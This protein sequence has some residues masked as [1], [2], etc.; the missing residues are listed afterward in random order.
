[1]RTIHGIDVHGIDVDAETRCAHYDT[2]CDVIAIRF[3]C[4]NE[5]Y[6]CF[7]C[8]DAVADHPRET[9]AKDER[10]TEAVLCGVCGS[11][12]T[13]SEYLGCESQCPE[14]DAEFNPGCAN[15]YELYFDG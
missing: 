13:I 14:C 4:C 12:L 15:H 10:D 2:E 7:R 8:H 11:E 6:P 5:Y 1:M 3:S 9:W